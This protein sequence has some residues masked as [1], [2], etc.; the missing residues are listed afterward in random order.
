MG[1]RQAAITRA[2]PHT[3]GPAL[4]LRQAGGAAPSGGQGEADASLFYRAK[5]HIS[6]RVLVF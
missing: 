2:I 1:C 4:V 3:R 5:T 6:G